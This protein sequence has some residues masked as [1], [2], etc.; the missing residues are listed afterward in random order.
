M[1][2]RRPSLSEL[3]DRS[4]VEHERSYAR[5]DNDA[6]AWASFA[7]TAEDLLGAPHAVIAECFWM[8]RWRADRFPRVVLGPRRAASL[9]ST[10]VAA[11]QMT[12]ILPPWR[13][14]LVELAD[15]P[16]TVRDPFVGGLAPID[17]VEVHFSTHHEGQPAWTMIA[18][19]AMGTSLQ[20]FNVFV[21]DW[22]NDRLVFEGPCDAYS[23]DVDDEDLRAL[24]VLSRLV[25]GL[26]LSLTTPEQ[27]D[28]AGRRAK[29]KSYRQ[30]R[31]GPAI[32]TDY[33]LG[34]DVRV[35]VREAVADYVARGGRAPRVQHLVRGHWK[36]QPHG[37]ERSLRKWIQV[38]P[39]W[40]GPDS[41]RFGRGG[42]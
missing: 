41:E 26:C 34:D 11:E 15:S 24:S 19:T 37:K 4:R 22:I 38:E 32:L 14:F 18:S 10:G 1:N 23:T 27:R 21:P 33:V 42:G 40:R 8:G 2:H 3:V 7:R 12:E 36:T 17:R 16:V 29:G 13:A 31:R 9:M 39:Y 5:S 25:A 30:R 35:D 6:D 28:D 20:R